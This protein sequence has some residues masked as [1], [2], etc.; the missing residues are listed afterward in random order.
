MKSSLLYF[1]YFISLF[2]MS[3]RELPTTEKNSLDPASESYGP[4]PPLIWVSQFDS[5]TNLINWQNRSPNAEGF[6]IERQ[7]DSLQGFF[8]VGEQSSLY[9][10]YYDHNSS[11]V[12][13]SIVTYR[14]RAYLGSKVGFPSNEK[15]IKMK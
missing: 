13:G 15:T 7:I 12:K 1:L 14:V 5:T 6:K 11:F 9:I 10:G 3:C 2:I 4:E 8:V